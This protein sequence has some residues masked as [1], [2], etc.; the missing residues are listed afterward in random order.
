M[1]GFCTKSTVQYDKKVVIVG[2]SFAGLHLA[3]Q[4]WDKFQVLIIDKNDYFEYVCTGS[5]SLVDDEHFDT[6]TLH[7]A[8][9]IRSHSNKATFMQGVLEKIEPCQNYIVVKT[10]SELGTEQIDYDFLVIC[11]GS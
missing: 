1:G 8:Q 2:C 4:L 11:T 5:R 6:T 7:Y 3:E 10:N 9:F